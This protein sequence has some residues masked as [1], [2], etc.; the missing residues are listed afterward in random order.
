V[1]VAHGSSTLPAAAAALA[2]TNVPF[3]YRQISES[4]FWAGRLD[5]R[6][7]VRALLTRAAAVVTLAA[8]QGDVLRTSFGV[9]A[10]KLHVVPN[11]VPTESFERATPDERAAARRRFGCS[12]G[13]VVVLSLGALVPEKGVAA[14]LDAVNAAATSGVDIEALVVGD[15]SHRTMLEAHVRRIGVEA[16]FVGVVDDARS[17]YAAADLFVLAS[18]G[19]DS[20]PATLIEAGAMGLACITTD[21][22]AITEVVD[23]GTTGLVVAPGDGAALADAVRT[24]VGDGDR[25]RVMGTKA[26][27]RVLERFDIDV[28]AEAW[29]QALVAAVGVSR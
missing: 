26:R 17:A 12:P 15:G 23:N 25:R 24:L 2:G 13:A 16:R 1:V 8:S 3:V 6:V 10:S 5:R 18:Q 21:V 27:T 28:V 7:R 19:G 22:G 14:M 9:R 4:L 11:A 29:E 20:M